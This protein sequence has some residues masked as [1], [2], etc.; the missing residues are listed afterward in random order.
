MD[1][2]EASH[3][4]T[5]EAPHQALQGVIDPR[6]RDLPEVPEEVGHTLVHYLH[7]G[8]YQT[9]QSQDDGD[10]ITELR[11]N[12][13]LYGVAIKYGLAGLATLAQEKIENIRE[14]AIFD[15]LGII[16]E[17]FQ[18]LLEDYA[19]LNPY[20][21]R[22]IKTAF[23]IDARLFEKDTFI[24]LFGE[25]KHFDRILMRIVAELFAE[26]MAAIHENTQ[27]TINGSSTEAIDATE[28]STRLSQP[29]TLHEEFATM[30]IEECTMEYPEAEAPAEAPAECAVEY[31]VCE[32]LASC[33]E[34]AVE[35]AVCEAT[36][37]TPAECAVEYAVCEVLPS[38]EEPAV[39]CAVCE[40]PAEAP[41]ECAVDHTVCEVLASCE[42]PAVGCA[43]EGKA[44]DGWG[45]WGQ[46]CEAAAPSEESTPVASAE[47]AS[48]TSEEATSLAEAEPVPEE[49]TFAYAEPAPVSSEEATFFAYAE[50]VFAEEA[51]PVAYAEPA[52]VFDE[53]PVPEPAAAIFDEE[54]VAEPAAVPD[55]AA[56]ESVPPT[57]EGNSKKKPKR[58]K[59]MYVIVNARSSKAIH[60]PD[61][62]SP[63]SE[64]EQSQTGMKGKKEKKKRKKTSSSLSENG[65]ASQEEV[66][67][68]QAKKEKKDKSVEPD[69]GP[70]LVP[71]LSPPVGTS[72]RDPYW[73]DIIER[74][75]P[76]TPESIVCASRAEHFLNGDMW[77]NCNKCRALIHRIS[78]ELAKIMT[79]A[80]D[81][82][83]IIG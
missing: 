1:T 26:K 48:I 8:T 16:K 9:L 37:E 51:T 29:E 31:A 67:K 28:N 76:V 39:E 53:A 27:L 79:A 6:P 69:S 49:A 14:V 73:L 64:N 83:E 55:Q 35:C 47:P 43:V 13:R 7:T 38:C 45:F 65:T 25:A 19:G 20:I 4:A 68:E 42:E 41:A 61:I 40:A 50:P 63:L 77:K 60:Q 24:E 58:G 81:E 32:V 74:T 23:E 36:A 33:D 62:F 44:P 46:S 21:K 78:I 75:E 54:S 72:I 80:E 17:A 56:S 11:R 5:D 70:E 12:V 22:E 57:E 2:G 66:K 59:G 10:K 3:Q 30:I 82:F 52:A 34:P 15:S 18:T 71:E